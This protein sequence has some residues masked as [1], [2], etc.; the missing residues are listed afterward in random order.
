[1]TKAEI[2]NKKM[3]KK[4]IKYTLGF[5]ILIFIYIIYRL[6]NIMILSGDD[7]KNKGI[8]QWTND[9][10]ISAK[11][12]RILDRDG[13]E[14]AVSANVY[15]VDLDL[16][17]LRETLKENNL[18]MNQIAPD[19][20]KILDMDS[21]TVLS[22]LTDPLPNGKPKNAAILKRRIEKSVADKIK[23]YSEEKNIIGLVISSDTKRY[24][25]NN[26]FASHAIGHTNSDGEGLTGIELYYNKYLAGMPGIKISETDRKSEDLPYNVSEYSKPVDGRDVVLTID[27]NIQLFAEKAAEKALADNGAK[28]V[29]IMVMNPNNGEILATVNKPDY[30]LNNPWP[31]ELSDSETEA[32]WRNKSISDAFEP[33]SIFKVVT[34]TAALETGIVKEGENFYCSGF[35]VVDGRAIHC[36]K[37]E[38][39][40]YQSFRDIISNSCN[41]GFMTLAERMGKETLNKYIEKYGFGKKTG[42]DLPGETEGI[43]KS[44][45]SMSNS[46][47]A[48]ISFG[49]SDTVSIVQYM[50]AFNAV[51][52]GGKLITPHL[53][54]EI[55]HYDEDNKKVVDQE[56]NPKITEGNF[57]PETLEEMRG[58]LEAAVEKNATAY[59]PGYHI[60]GK[61]GTAQ[62][63]D[64]ENGGYA[65]DKYIGSF[66]GMAPANDPK[67]TIVVT[68]DEPDP[69][70]YYGNEV[71]APVGKSLFQDIF[72]YL[73]LNPEESADKSK[74]NLLKNIAIPEIRGRKKDEGIKIL[75]DNNLNMKIEGD[76]DYIVDVSP[77]PGYMVKEGTEIIVYAGKKSDTD[78]IVAVPDLNGYSKEK[79]T[80]LLV[81]LGLSAE[82]SGE[83]V[84]S[85]QSIAP[86]QHVKKGTVINMTLTVSGD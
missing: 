77:K 16:K 22:I 46:D 35:S 80:E 64:F 73:A 59:I 14:L 31:E 56:F 39:H 71:A 58:H 54:K 68:V 60:A 53:M 43:V 67:I 36:W 65:K 83:G 7:Y 11:R 20:A 23:S 69:S 62:K 9:S 66:V 18:T 12:G 42:V 34:A 70:K 82:Y 55:V 6:C 47:L 51:A 75:N 19:L 17:S 38:G 4:R 30:N 41:V 78:N 21:K 50:M 24:Y 52:N 25:P 27:Q 33:G 37:T 26:N 84:V 5:T 8:Q 76:G 79:A 1:M 13:N 2:K 3:N 57:R 32:L 45:E 44:V 15:R 63:P 29:S 86:R 49:Q 10:R 28:G 81:S 74:D 72:N 48:T 61:T 85:Q 40:G